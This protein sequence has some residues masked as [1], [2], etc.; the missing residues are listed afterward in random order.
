MGGLMDL[1]KKIS[2]K[3]ARWYKK[4]FS[5]PQEPFPVAFLYKKGTKHRD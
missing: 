5:Q 1:H 3:H 4:R 2:F